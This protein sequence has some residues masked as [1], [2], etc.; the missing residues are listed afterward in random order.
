MTSSAPRYPDA[1]VD[2]IAE[3][4]DERLPIAEVSRRLGALAMELGVVRPSYVHLRRLVHA[5][6]ERRR[7]ID[8]LRD[9]V[10]A[11]LA[12]G[13]VRHPEWLAARIA[14]LP[15]GPRGGKER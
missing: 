2:A 14:E 13:R 8:E 5:S 11:D 7:A 3:L 9:A 15:E 10:L 6:R 12:A 1:L 4:D